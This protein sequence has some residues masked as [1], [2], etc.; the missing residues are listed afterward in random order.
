[1]QLDI[2]LTSQEQAALMRLAQAM[3]KNVQEYLQELVQIELEP[4]LVNAKTVETS[5][6]KKRLDALAK[7]H[8]GHGNVDCSR[9]AIYGDHH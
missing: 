4:E 6:F 7:L 1:M 3:G 9:E 8:A 2:N 5:E